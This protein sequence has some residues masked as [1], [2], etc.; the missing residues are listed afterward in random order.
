MTWIETTFSSQLTSKN[1]KYFHMQRRNSG[2]L[3]SLKK[4][5]FLLTF[6]FSQLSQTTTSS[7]PILLFILFTFFRFLLL[8]F[9]SFPF[10]HHHHII[11]INKSIHIIFI[12]LLLMMTMID[13][14]TWRRIFNWTPTPFAFF[15]ALTFN[16]WI[17]TFLF[18]STWGLGKKWKVLFA[19]DCGQFCYYTC[20]K[21]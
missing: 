14:I 19:D 3:L 20:L 9:L 17:S 12:L 8:S 18:T 21:K 2:Q 16:L 1:K 7:S 4:I 5:P 15:S 6:D 10:L 13:I 11:V